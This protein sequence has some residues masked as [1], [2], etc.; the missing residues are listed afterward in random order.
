[1]AEIA[2]PVQPQMSCSAPAATST[3]L[4]QAIEQESLAGA[5]IKTLQSFGK[6]H[7]AIPGSGIKVLR[8][9]SKQMCTV[10]T[11]NNI[12]GYTLLLDGV[13]EEVPAV[14]LL[15]LAQLSRLHVK[16]TTGE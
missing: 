6:L 5:C 11:R 12:R 4:G 8:L 16:V 2:A 9:V 14:K 15:K 1:M 13:T 7:N 10:M 3:T